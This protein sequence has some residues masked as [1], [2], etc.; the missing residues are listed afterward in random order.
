LARQQTALGEAV[1]QA[2][3]EAVKKDVAGGG[4]L[5]KATQPLAQAADWMRQAAADLGKGDGAAATQG[6]AAVLKQ[7]EAARQAI[8]QLQRGADEAKPA[9]TLAQ[10]LETV[11]AMR[12]AME[13]N[14]AP[15]RP[16][17]PGQPGQPGR[18][19]QGRDQDGP[20]QGQGKDSA[21]ARNT[22]PQQNRQGQPGQSQG[23][24]KTGP[25]GDGAQ[26]RGAIAPREQG[27]GGGGDQLRRPT[28]EIM[29]LPPVDPARRESAQSGG[30]GVES[31]E[32]P[33]TVRLNLSELHKLTRMDRDVAPV[34]Q[35][36]ILLSR[37]AED[38]GYTPAKRIEVIGQLGGQLA[39][40]EELLQDKLNMADQLQRLEQTPDAELPE[41]F[42]A[43]AAKYFEILGATRSGAGAADAQ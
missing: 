38:R 24:G 3:Q 23:Q 5:G 31:V 4:T 9:D 28:G 15:G 21:Q 43:M 25:D 35:E 6:Q 27:G 42:R 18:P 26:G 8:G 1:N 22:S 19:G 2:I 16:G 10:A 32:M 36:L 17:Q 40:L 39:H 7:F 41:R 13:Q 20:G 34:V 33:E 12:Q 30:R 37:Q 11:R 14:Q 29:P